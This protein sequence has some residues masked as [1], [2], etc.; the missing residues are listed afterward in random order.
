LKE[1]GFLL[2]FLIDLDCA[3]RDK[4]YHCTI[5]RKNP[6]ETTA[7]GK[8]SLVCCSRVRLA[9]SRMAKQLECWISRWLDEETLKAIMDS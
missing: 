4:K 1:L 2:A 5:R 8:V 3:G 9:V 7:R 6:P